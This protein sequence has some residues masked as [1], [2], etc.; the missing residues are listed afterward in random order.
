MNMNSHSYFYLN[1]YLKEG[2]DKMP[3]ETF[4]NL[5]EEKRKKIEKTALSEFSKYGYFNSKISRI[6]KKSGISVG[7]FYQYFD[8]MDDLFMQIFTIIADRKMQY[9]KNELADNTDQSFEGKIRAMFSGGIKFALNEPDCF[10]VANTFKSL[11]STPVFENIMKYYIKSE[12]TDFL[13]IL[14]EEGKQSGEI[15]EDLSIEL[16]TSLLVN[17]QLSVI[18]YVGLFDN[19]E[20]FTEENMKR[21]SDIA[22]DILFHGIG[23]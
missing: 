23:K 10:N 21:M 1:L 22:V 8:N 3:K 19:E 15:R 17:V 20:K 13:V 14:I 7:S 4:K 18:E 12:N 9:I 2:E 16:F 6:A 11:K 5:K